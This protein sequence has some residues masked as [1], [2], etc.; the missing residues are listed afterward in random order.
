MA[1]STKV[2]LPAMVNQ[3]AVA[4]IFLS[5]LQTK[6]AK[7]STLDFVVPISNPRYAKG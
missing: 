4:K 1:I 2:A 6:G 7:C 5:I 3:V